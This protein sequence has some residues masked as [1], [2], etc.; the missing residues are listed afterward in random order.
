MTGNYY[1]VD[2]LRQK[3]VYKQIVSLES[4]VEAAPIFLVG[5][6][7]LSVA[8]V[9]CKSTLFYGACFNCVLYFVARTQM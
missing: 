9:N 8:A 6:H 2:D 7:F 5:H 4:Q 1:K 3:I